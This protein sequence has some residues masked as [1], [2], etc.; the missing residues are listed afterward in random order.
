MADG[1]DTPMPVL[2]P[3][4]A[5]R[6]VKGFNDAYRLDRSYRTAHHGEDYVDP[7]IGPMAVEEFRSPAKGNRSWSLEDDGLVVSAFEVDHSPVAPVV[8][9]R[10][11]YQGRSAVISA[12]TVYSGNLVKAAKN[13]DLLIHDALSI[14]LLMMV[15]EAQ[16]EAGNPA[17]G[18]ILAD[19]HDYHATAPGPPMPPGR[20]APGRLP[21][22]TSCP[23]CPWGL[24]DITW[25]TPRTGSTD[26]SGSP[27]TVTSTTSLPRGP[28]A[29]QPDQPPPIGWRHENPGSSR[30]I[31]PLPFCSAW[32][33]LPA[34]IGDPAGFPGVL[35]PVDFQIVNRS[36]PG[37]RRR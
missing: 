21:S 32:W 37:A 34:G 18:K 2:G 35:S 33:P 15:A 20:P 29:Q 12:D 6:V 1:T 31:L 28:E 13:T 11:D 5:E 26:P 27:P 17:R 10:F 23:R 4:G 24:E 19:V 3:P 30:L 22:P 8:G 36:T 9:F 16:T 14:E 7:A 25:P